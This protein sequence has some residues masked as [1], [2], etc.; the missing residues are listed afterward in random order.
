MKFDESLSL[1]NSGIP[2]TRSDM[3][4]YYFCGHHEVK[5]V[6]PHVYETIGPFIGLYRKGGER[7]WDK[8]S[9]SYSEVIAE[10]WEVYE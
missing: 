10:D 5:E 9:F 4:D 1:L 7:L 2:V 6:G 8:Y 3:G